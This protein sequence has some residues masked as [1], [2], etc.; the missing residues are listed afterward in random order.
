MGEREEEDEKEKEE[1]EVRGGEEQWEWIKGASCHLLLIRGG[2]VMLLM[3]GVCHLQ[4]VCI[5]FS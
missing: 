1:V 2:A 3:T 4:P 5:S